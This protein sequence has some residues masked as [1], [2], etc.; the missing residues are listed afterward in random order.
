MKYKFADRLKQASLIER[1][2][3][4]AIALVEGL[5]KPVRCSVAGI[6]GKA[7]PEGIPCLVSEDKAGKGAVYTVVAEKSGYAYIQH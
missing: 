2:G 5:E 1:D 6:T 4:H 3:G 7:G